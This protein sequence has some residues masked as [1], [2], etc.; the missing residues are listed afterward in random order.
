MLPVG[1]HTWRSLGSA[2]AATD[3]LLR[4]YGIDPASIDPETDLVTS[5]DGPVVLAD[6]STR[7]DPGP[8]EIQHADLPAY[9]AA[10]H[11]LITESAIEERGWE[12]RREA[13]LIE[14]KDPLT[15][16][17]I[18]D[19]RDAAARLGLST[20]TRISQTTLARF[21]TIVT[22]IGAL[23]GLAIVAMAVGLIRS[24]SARDVRTLTA[25]GASS[26]SRRAV[27]ATTAGTLAGLGVVIGVGGA[28]LALVAGYHADLGQLLPLPWPQLLLLVV[29]L[30]VAATAAGWLLAG[31]EPEHVSR[32][33]FG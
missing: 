6:F 14:T 13:W 20:E 17:Q 10:P 15:A 8:T 5:E 33:T 12:Q 7:D 25:T 28:Y 9:F 11:A 22:V 32:Q 1:D 23:L 16:S 30:P 29:G 3:A 26:R 24:E 2:Y 27:T 31:R 21:R 18:R 4:H 19:A